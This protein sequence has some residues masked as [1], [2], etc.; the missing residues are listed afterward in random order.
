MHR[1]RYDWQLYG[2]ALGRWLRGEDGLDASAAGA[3]VAELL[4]LAR[5]W[6]TRGGV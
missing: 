5:S 4:T 6:L 3:N 2:F 1:L